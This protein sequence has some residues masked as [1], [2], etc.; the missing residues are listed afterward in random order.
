[1]KN[2]EKELLNK[3]TKEELINKIKMQQHY[4]FDLKGQVRD[5]KKTN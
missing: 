4:I 1:M 2:K 5:L 3:Y